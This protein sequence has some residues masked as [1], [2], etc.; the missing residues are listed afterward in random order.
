[1]KSNEETKVLLQNIIRPDQQNKHVRG[2]RKTRNGGVIIGTYAKEDIEK[3][4]QSAKKLKISGFA[5]G[6]LHKCKPRLMVIGAPSS[7]Q[8]TEVFNIIFHQNLADEN[9]GMT[10]DT[11]LISIALSHKSGKKDAETCNYVI[12]VPAQ[13]RKALITKD[14]P[15]KRLHFCKQMTSIR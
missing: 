10:V 8:E 5:I 11:F 9:P 6:E 2:L 15:C 12:K 14:V 3:L 7:M 13:I 4:K 1:M